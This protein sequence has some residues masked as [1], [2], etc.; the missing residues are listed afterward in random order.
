MKSP[1]PVENAAAPEK[2]HT[3]LF[4]GVAVAAVVVFAGV[5]VGLGVG[6]SGGGSPPTTHLGNTVET[7]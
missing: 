5:G 3:L 1:P 2:S 6:L 7:F 4:V